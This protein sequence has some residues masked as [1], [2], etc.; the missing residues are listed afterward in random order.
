MNLCLFCNMNDFL[1]KILSSPSKSIVLP[2]SKELNNYIEKKVIVSK[3]KREYEISFKTKSSISFLISEIEKN[4]ELIFNS[5]INEVLEIP[6]KIESIIN[7]ELKTN[8][9]SLYDFIPNILVKNYLILKHKSKEID[10]VEYLSK[11]DILEDKNYKKERNVRFLFEIIIETKCSN[12]EIVDLIILHF[13]IEQRQTVIYEFVKKLCGRYLD[14]AIKIY[15]DYDKR[16]GEEKTLAVFYFLSFLYNKTLNENYLEIAFKNYKLNKREYFVFLYNIDYSK[17]VGV[18]RIVEQL[19]NI[20]SVPQEFLL[21]HVFALAKLLSHK[22]N[23]RENIDF[24]F[25]RLNN[26]IKSDNE[27]IGYQVLN[28]C[29]QRIDDYEERRFEL[30]MTAL[31]EGKRKMLEWKFLLNSFNDPKHFFDLYTFLLENFGIKANFNFIHN[32]F[33]AMLRVNE[34]ETL[35]QINGM[36][37][38]ENMQ[39]RFGAIRLLSNT[40]HH[41]DEGFILKDTNELLQL[42]AI[43]AFRIFPLGI[44]EFFKFLIALRKSKF[45]YVKQYL[46]DT[47]NHLSVEAY[48]D[49]LFNLMEEFIPKKERRNVFY[50]NYLKFKDE[51]DKYFISKLEMKELSPFENETGFMNNYF[52]LEREQDSKLMEEAKGKSFLS[53]LGDSQPY[54]VVRANAWRIEGRDVSPL[55][56]TG[57]SRM[58][59]FRMYKFPERMEK[60]ISSTKCKF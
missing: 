46:L 44:E 37:N 60:I 42:R 11:I 39:V 6:K 45:N 49:S 22:K 58:L 36:F 3:S 20:E 10:L 56:S 31:H 55:T 32:D 47:I 4:T 27:D 5:N 23:S 14:R 43:E 15:K 25:K 33:D 50:K 57:L 53:L 13:A 26:Y 17:K 21:N 48:G 19:K 35:S 16:V 24:L 1:L 41:I 51:I 8:V 54:I 29:L 30:L 52:E 12:K 7:Q 40:H 9:L 59:D 34:E 38:S 28:E 2:K 18:N